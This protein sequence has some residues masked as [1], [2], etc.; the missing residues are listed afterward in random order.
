MLLSCRFLSPFLPSSTPTPTVVTPALVPTPPVVVATPTPLPEPLVAEAAVRQRLLINLYDR[1]NPGVVNIDVVAGTGDE[2]SPFG[3]GSGFLIDTE[4]HIVTNDHV[5]EGGDVFWVTFSDGSIRSAE[6]LGADPYSDLAVLL[7]EDLPPS[8]VPLELGD[9]DALEVGQEVVAIGNPFGLEGTMT[10][11]IISALGRSLP[12]SVTTGGGTFSIPRV[13]QTDAAINPGNSGGPL[14]DLQ[15]RVIGVN[16]AIRTVFGGSIGIGFAIPV[17]IVKRIIPQLIEEGEFHYPYLGITAETEF[18]LN[19]L[20]VE[21][22]L[23]T[24]RGV[25]V[26]TVMPGGPAEQAGVRG[27]SEE[28]EV[29]GRSVTVGGDIIVAIDG[30][31]VEDFNG[32]VSYLILETEVGQTVTLT[33]LRDGETLQIPVE[34]GERP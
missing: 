23:P 29:W 34:L 2:A 24:D 28:A 9:S 8:A 12:S 22:G 30:H 11:G 5:V 19:Q 25:L 18:T 27:G 20:A 13:I 14:L 31:P 7:V 1:V 15:G 32:L 16:T 4:G 33:V 10:T 26:A 17:N 21:L 6:V 3:N